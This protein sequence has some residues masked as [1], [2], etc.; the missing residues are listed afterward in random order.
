MLLVLVG[1]LGAAPA[2]RP[3]LKLTDKQI[4]AGYDVPLKA[5]QT[6]EGTPRRNGTIKE[7][8]GS[9]VQIAIIG[10]EGQPVMIQLPAMTLV[11]GAFEGN[12][13]TLTAAQTIFCNVVDV[14]NEQAQ[15]KRFVRDLMDA[16]KRQ[17][18]EVTREFGDVRAVLEG[19]PQADGS[20]IDVTLTLTRKPG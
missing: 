17:D 1:M 5:S 20:A 18:Q 19:M 8:D 4:L 16:M 2:T 11:P 6:R 9:R 15:F 13:G 7:K 10:P 3:S 12:A 14:E